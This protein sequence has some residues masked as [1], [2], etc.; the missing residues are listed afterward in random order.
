MRGVAVS[1]VVVDAR[2]MPRSNSQPDKLLPFSAVP[3]LYLNLC[4]VIT[5]LRYH[6][7]ERSPKLDEHLLSGATRNR[8]HG[9]KRVPSPGIGMI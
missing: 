6:T 4:L 5:R 7:W 1:D 3:K 2:D 8:E 9:W